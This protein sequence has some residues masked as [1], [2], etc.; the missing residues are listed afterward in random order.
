MPSKKALEYA[1]ERIEKLDISLI[2]PQHG[3]ILDTFEAQEIVIKRLK[4]LTKVG[5]DYFLE[6]EEH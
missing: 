4:E 6:E 3:S 5:I 2:A 1:L